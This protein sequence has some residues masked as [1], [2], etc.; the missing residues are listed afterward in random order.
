MSE[1]LN[2]YGQMDASSVAS[3][4]VIDVS[5]NFGSVQIYFA[6]PD[7]NHTIFVNITPGQAED[8]SKKLIDAADLV[9]Q[10]KHE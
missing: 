7:E 5:P 6:S 9:R 8:L 2:D 1:F 4:G 10:E 3:I